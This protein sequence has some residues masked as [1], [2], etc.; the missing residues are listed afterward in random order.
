[1]MLF[2]RKVVIYLAATATAAVALVSSHP[3]AAQT[4]KGP[5]TAA[6]NQEVRLVV[7]DLKT[8][9]L[10]KASEWAQKLK[11]DVSSPTGAQWLADPELTIGLGS[12]GLKVRV[13]FSAD[14][15]GVYVLVLLDGNSG[16]LAL[17]RITVGGPAPVVPPVN[18]TTPGPV[19]PNQPA[20][21]PS[22]V[23]QVTL[24]YEQRGNPLNPQVLSALNTLNR[25]GVLSTTFDQDTTDGTG[26]TPEQ[27]KA[28]LAAAKQAGLPCL[29]VQ[30]GQSVVRVI[31][32]P[33]TSEHVLEAVR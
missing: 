3:A 11:L 12:G 8:P 17:H 29:V 26:D 31:S 25:Q 24:V 2:P 28:A 9:E 4:I 32:N 15:P 20:P 19:D 5:D 22:K 13:Y 10:A 1:M 23:T 14:K 6:V 16:G 21:G 27:Y 7:E 30:A 33:T 18:P